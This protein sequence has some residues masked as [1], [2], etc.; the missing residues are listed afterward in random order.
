MRL[1]TFFFTLCF[2]LPFTSTAHFT[3]HDSVIAIQQ[4]KIGAKRHKEVLFPLELKEAEIRR[5]SAQNVAD[6]LRLLAGVQVKDY[7]GI[8]GLKTVN[9]RTLGSQHV[10]VSY[11]GAPV[12]NAQ[13]GIIDL[14]RFSLG[15]VERIS[16]YYGQQSSLLQPARDY[17]SGA[18]V[19]LQPRTPHVSIA[20]PYHLQ[21][22][23]R[24]GSFGLINPQIH[25]EQRLSTNLS[26][27]LNGEITEAHGRYPFRYVGYNRTGKKVYDTTA[28]RR[29]GDVHIQRL[30]SALHWLFNDGELR[31]QL[32][33]YHSERGL[34]GPIV[35]NVWQRG[36]RLADNNLFA[37]LNLQKDFSAR[38][39]TKL[40]AKYAYNNTHYRQLDSRFY[41]ANLFY[42]Q[43]EAYF[44]SVHALQLTSWLEGALAYD[45]QWNKIESYDR[46]RHSPPLGFTHPQ[47]SAHY[48]A[49]TLAFQYRTLR[50]RTSAVA[51]G[52]YQHEQARNT[53][54][55]VWQVC[56]ALFASY[57]LPILPSISLHGFWKQTLRPPTFNELYYVDWGNPALKPEYTTQRSIG[58]QW[59]YTFT[60]TFFKNVTLLADLYNNSI[61]N[62]II[63]YPTRG[64]FRWTTINLGH[65][66]MHGLECSVLLQTQALRQHEFSLRL[67]YAYTEARDL[68]DPHAVYYK[69]QIPYIPWHS[70]ALI[71]HYTWRNYSLYYSFLYTGERYHQQENTPFN[72]EPAW[73][74]NDLAIAL[75]FNIF[76]RPVLLRLELNNLL[77][78]Q[79]AVVLNYPMPGRNFRVTIQTSLK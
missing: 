15:N 29:N 74:T 47:R 79:Y 52:V 24:T 66:V 33:A 37:Q 20:Q 78:Q 4:V 73:Y 76:A 31:F 63:A 30:E 23:L 53:S 62:K 42:Q 38:Y 9:V 72:Y 39:R 61:R 51:T 43:H 3:Q 22:T 6:A 64:Q 70:G 36:E 60:H 41:A 55:T 49:T 56:P 8:G 44:S 10:A 50:L 48:L 35:N 57:S 7:G 34:P 12:G 59:H 68:T 32:Y 28:T 11:D 71:F 21:A 65:V 77:D 45:F 75:N 69:H 40:L 27:S 13:N 67:Q 26:L 58:A 46:L 54:V 1:P 19:A 5:C 17:L 14:G 16:L 2:L 25:Y 18:L